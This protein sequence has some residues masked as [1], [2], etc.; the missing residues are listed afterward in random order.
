MSFKVSFDRTVN[1]LGGKSRIE[2]GQLYLSFV[3]N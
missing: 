2:L 3:M 1:E